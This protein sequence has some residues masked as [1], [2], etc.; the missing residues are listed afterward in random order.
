[1]EQNPVYDLLRELD[2][3][4]VD[5]EVLLKLLTILVL[6]KK[7]KLPEVKQLTQT[8]ADNKSEWIGLLDALTNSEEKQVK[9]LFSNNENIK[10]LPMPFMH[11]ALNILLKYQDAEL[12][13]LAIEIMKALGVNHSSRYSGSISIDYSVAVLVKGILGDINNRSVYAIGDSLPFC[14]AASDTSGEV[15][16]ETILKAGNRAD[17]FSLISKNQF[18]VTY[19]NHLLNPAYTKSNNE[20]KQ[21]DFGVSFSPMNAPI[22]RELNKTVD[23]FNR[24]DIKPRKAEAA[25]IQHL[26]KQCSELVVVSVIEG[27]LYS[28]MEKELRRYLLDNGMLKAVISLPSG[29]FVNTTVK[30]S[31]LVLEPKGGSQSVRFVDLTADKFVKK[32]T[33]QTVSLINIDEALQNLNSIDKLDSALSIDQA[34][35]AKNN[36]SFDVSD[37]ILSP[38]QQK[39]ANQINDAETVMLGDI[40]RFERG[41][42]FKT[43]DGECT[44]LEVGVSEF[45][46]IGN[47]SSPTKEIKISDSELKKNK[48]GVLQPNDIIFVLKGSAGKVGI[49]P[50]DP[51]EIGDDVWMANRSGIVLRANS[52]K[53]DAKT[54]YAYLSSELGQVQIGGLIKGSTIPNISLKELKE[55]RILVPTKKEQ[56]KAIALVDNGRKTQKEIK[57]LLL[58]QKQSRAELWNV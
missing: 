14:I 27:F 30:A 24:F 13:N 47:I 15:Y 52:E 7:G 48:S 9:S 26:I 31:L 41:L 50:E 32:I 38:I 5:Y 54:L 6:S 18:D 16:F 11:R 56:E 25:N 28:S 21:F 20:L 51:Q 19:T 4:K 35:I 23:S 49:V 44:V 22:P 39:V 55:L 46:E 43:E 3:S 33:R 34:E 57:Q 10:S 45:N 36:Y 1:M 12:P 8:I 42:P 58:K 37:Y 17:A 53:I 2:K 40:V 29:I